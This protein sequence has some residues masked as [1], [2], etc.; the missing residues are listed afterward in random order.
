MD[1]ENGAGAEMAGRRTREP[2][3]AGPMPRRALSVLEPNQPAMVPSADAGKQS[4]RMRRSVSDL[5]ASSL[6][7][8]A[9]GTVATVTA[10]PART[11]RRRRNTL[12]TG[13]T[14][15]SYG[16]YARSR[17]R[18]SVDAAATLS[19]AQP[20]RSRSPHA[21][22]LLAVR[23]PLPPT[24]R[25]IAVLVVLVTLA[26]T[27][28]PR[29][30]VSSWLPL[31]ATCVAPLALL[32][33]R[34]R[35]STADVLNAVLAPFHAGTSTVERSVTLANVLLLGLLEHDAASATAWPFAM[36]AGAAWMASFALRLGL[37]LLF[38][39]GTGW[40][41]PSLFFSSSVHECSSGASGVSGDV[42][43][44]STGLSTIALASTLALDAVVA[45]TSAPYAIQFGRR[46]QRVEL[47]RRHVHLALASI[48]V[49][50]LVQP[51][52]SMSA[53]IAGGVL[54]VG[55]APKRLGGRG[56]DG[57]R[58]ARSIIAL[59]V[60]IGSVV[61]IMS[62]HRRMAPTSI[63]PIRPDQLMT[64][65]LMTAPRPGDPDFL[66]QTLDSYLV[67]L[68]PASSSTRLIVYNHFSSHVA[69]DRA[70]ANRSDSALP[71]DWVRRP[72]AVDRLDQRLHVAR[73]LAHAVATTDS[74]YVML[75]EDDF[76]LCDPATQ[77]WSKLLRGL[78]ELDVRMPD[79]EDGEPGHC[80]LF[81][82]TG[83]S[84]LI[85]RSEIARRLPA[86]LLGADDMNGERRERDDA[87][88]LVE[89]APDLVIQDCLRGLLPGC[90]T[91]GSGRSVRSTVSSARDPFGSVGDRRGKSGLAATERLLMRHLGYARSTSGRTYPA[92][93][94]QCGQRHPFVRILRCSGCL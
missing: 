19:S 75:A 31:P 73:A 88:V 44:T 16:V 76:P 86:L 4:L 61:A 35:P 9:P 13:R 82:G 81:V 38:S 41:Y 54:T 28:L 20:R 10:P 46:S 14:G 57:G 43:L 92:S 69:Y 12:P 48:N 24:T 39:R 71:I 55:I 21:Q 77:S 34:P 11:L 23:W 17:R 8:R 74:R 25:M 87:D 90:E 30:F 37:G 40:A 47:P 29:G 70:L 58:L 68:D 78:H 45:A 84:G 91:C 27:Q 66:A 67:N 93:W 1:D 3:A 7:S 51:W 32:S 18:L 6:A 42:Q 59:L 64:V 56:V 85:M 72:G 50:A 63:A 65:V 49:L 2:S 60:V 36:L 94:A 79:R 53:V 52:T 83:G 5:G 62:A 15:G 22:L 26:S 80:G 33:D 89:R